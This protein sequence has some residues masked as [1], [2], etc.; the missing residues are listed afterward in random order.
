LRTTSRV[1]HRLCPG[2]AGPGDVDL[3]VGGSCT[4]VRGRLALRLVGARRV[5]GFDRRRTPDVTIETAR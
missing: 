4:D 5:V 1:A 3:R 2:R